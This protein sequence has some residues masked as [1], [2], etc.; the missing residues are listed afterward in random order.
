LP[1]ELLGKHYYR[2]TEHGQEAAIA[3]RLR[4]VREK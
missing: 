1:E 3:E 2:P 4:K